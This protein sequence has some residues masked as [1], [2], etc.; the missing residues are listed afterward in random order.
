MIISFILLFIPNVLTHTKIIS[1][2]Y[3][4]AS[5]RPSIESSFNSNND[6][7][8]IFLNTFLPFTI[9]QESYYEKMEREWKVH[10]EVSLPL[11][12]VVKVA[13]YKTN[14]ETSA[15]FISGMSVYV[16]K[17]NVWY[18]DRGIG[19][20]YKFDD[21]E[22]SLVHYL[23]NN[24][25]IGNKVFA[26]EYLN[27]DNGTF[28]IGG[29]END[30]HLEMKY[31][32][33]CEVDERVERWGCN[34]TKIKFN[35]KEYK[36]NNFTLF[37]S[38]FY[39]KIYSNGLYDFLANNVFIEEIKNKTC[40]T[41]EIAE[42]RYAMRCK[43][44]FKDLEIYNSTIKFYFNRLMIVYPIKELF[45]PYGLGDL[46][47]FFYTNPYD[48]YRDYDIIF[49]LH[50]LRNFN[51]TVYNYETKRVGFY[52]DRIGINTL[53]DSDYKGV[54][55]VISNVI[56]ILLMCNIIVVIYYKIKNIKI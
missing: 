34:L 18:P 45:E 30:K 48:Y 50:F 49:S 7:I 12:E 5:H 20:G 16:A 25:M 42:S 53:N 39:G 37:H 15:F 28:Y 55:K 9:V 47:S 4:V 10:D 54:I 8:N 17:N 29:V 27:E 51:Y 14:I 46:K 44:R 41:E 23:Y 2:P 24:K 31:K 33:E 40:Y 21:E 19:L 56:V 1:I 43:R 11:H 36:F 38:T 3:T 32:G 6:N 26:F 13:H 35:N 22:F 52:S